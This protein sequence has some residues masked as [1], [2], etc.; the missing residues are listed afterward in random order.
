VARF[1]WEKTA[2]MFRAH[3]RRLLGASL[4]DEDLSL[5]TEMPSL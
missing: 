4:S 5:V 1:T 3:Y 2:K